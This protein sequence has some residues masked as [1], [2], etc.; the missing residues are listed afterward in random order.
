VAGTYTVWRSSRLPNMS[1]MMRMHHYKRRREVMRTLG[2]TIACALTVLGLMMAVVHAD[3][4]PLMRDVELEALEEAVGWPNPD[5]A[6]VVPLAGR[7]IASSRNQDAYRFFHERAQAVPDRAL[8]L[9]LEGFFQARSAGDVFLLRR[10]AWVNAAVGKL[11][12]AV[13]RDP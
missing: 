11:D 2:L 4:R 6:T 3:E 7:F 1:R 12:R 13:A 10:S 5:V 9:A 8:F